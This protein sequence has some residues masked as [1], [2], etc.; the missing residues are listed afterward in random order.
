MHTQLLVVAVLLLPQLAV[1]TVAPAAANTIAQP[2]CPSKCGKVEIPYP[3]GL[4]DHPH[5]YRKGFEVTCH[6]PHGGAPRLSLG[7]TTSKGPDVLEISV[8]HS[9]VKIRSPVRSFNVGNMDKVQIHVLE[10]GKPYV[11]G[12]AAQNL[13]LHTGCGF[14][15]ESWG[16]GSVRE[17][18]LTVPLP[19]GGGEPDAIDRLRR[20]QW[21]RL[22]LRAHAGER[23]RFLHH[24]VRLESSY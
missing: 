9:T 8:K 23:P 5:C 21:C 3:F 15:A 2:G 1:T 10:P 6:R 22:L 13:L 4:S 11:L 14:L 12:S 18:M 16:Y 19:G 20:V 7:T 24:P 17:R